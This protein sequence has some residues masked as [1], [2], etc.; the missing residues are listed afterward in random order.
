MNSS[1]KSFEKKMLWSAYLSFM[2][3]FKE[4]FN[5]VNDTKKGYRKFFIIRVFFTKCYKLKTRQVYDFI[6]IDPKSATP[7]F[8]NCYLHAKSHL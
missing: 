2:I 7:T 5:K 1:L 8:S 4:S 6:A 3:Q